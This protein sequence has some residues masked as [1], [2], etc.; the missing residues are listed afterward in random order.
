MSKQASIITIAKQGDGYSVDAR[1]AFG[2]GWTRHATVAELS[3]TIIRAWQMYGN[4]PLGCEII[5]D[6]PDDVKE[7]VNKLQSSS[8]GGK[9]VITLRVS[10]VEADI[11]RAR[12]E[13]ENLSAN[14]WIKNLI[15]GGD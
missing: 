1:G 9:A 7:L 10:E 11:I 8:G 15:F 3:S 5:G 12:A 4:N 2:G 13:A 14:Q 6:L